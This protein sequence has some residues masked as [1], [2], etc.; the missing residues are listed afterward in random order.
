[1]TGVTAGGEQ[2]VFC[3][4]TIA[5]VNGRHDLHRREPRSAQV[6]TCGTSAA[7]DLKNA[8]QDRW[9]LSTGPLCGLLPTA[10]K[11]R[12]QRILSQYYFIVRR[13]AQSLPPRSVARRVA[14]Y[15][16]LLTVFR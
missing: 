13:R 9:S 2:S 12:E 15:A 3:D 11:Y 16:F 14:V 6:Y 7:M 1:M 4:S 8:M 10:L 5:S